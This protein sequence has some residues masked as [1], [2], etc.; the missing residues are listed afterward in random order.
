MKISYLRFH[1]SDLITIFITIVFLLISTGPLLAEEGSLEKEKFQNSPSLGPDQVQKIRAMQ[2]GLFFVL[3][4]Y[5]MID[6]VISSF[7]QGKDYGN[8]QWIGA[9][10][11]LPGVGQLINKEYLKGDSLLFLTFACSQTMKELGGK[12]GEVG[13]GAN[14]RWTEALKFLQWGLQSYA[15]MDA[16]FTAMTTDP[17]YDRAFWIGSVSVIPGAGQFINKDWW[18]GGTLLAGALLLDQMTRNFEDQAKKERAAFNQ[19]SNHGVNYS[20]AI[21]SGGFLTGITTKF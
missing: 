8:S 18:K 16:G 2:E 14:A 1:I 17:T 10:S 9:S 4:R 13:Q 12:E 19:K 7:E 3:E 21:V 11:A 6:A 15:M 5:A 20:L